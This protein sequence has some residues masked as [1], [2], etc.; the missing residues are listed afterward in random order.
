[1]PH[2]EQPGPPQERACEPLMGS[3]DGL[4]LWRSLL[5]WAKAVA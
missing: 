3:E 2:P 1:M 5:E 4:A